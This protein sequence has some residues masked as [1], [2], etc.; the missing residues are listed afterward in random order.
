MMLMAILIPVVVEG[1]T[2]A[3]RSAMVARG[4]TVALQLGD[5]LLH[6]MIITDQWRQQA[7]S[8]EFGEEFPGFRWQLIDEGWEFDTMRSL[9]LVVIYEVQGREYSLSLTTLAEEESTQ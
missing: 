1:I 8:G 2:I 5:A 4:K 7:R 9:S 6:E 3:N